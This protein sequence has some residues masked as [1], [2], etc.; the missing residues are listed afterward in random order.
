MNTLM[1]MIR[2]LLA[3]GAV[4]GLLWL[5]N[6]LGRGGRFSQLFQGSTEAEVEIRAQR[7]L[8]RNASVALIRSGDRH[9]LVGVTEHGVSLLAEGDDLASTPSDT[10]DTSKTETSNGSQ[11]SHAASNGD[12]VEPS[13]AVAASLD[14]RLAGLTIPIPRR[15]R[16]SAMGHAR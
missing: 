9:L 8:G 14:L 5:T 3:L 6:R 2:L 12:A 10:T 11:L 16:T 13:E 1:L 4:V 7:G 15:A